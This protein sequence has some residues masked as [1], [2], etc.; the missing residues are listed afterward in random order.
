MFTYSR[1][2]IL[3]TLAGLAG[4]D[5]EDV[6][7]TVEIVRPVKTAVIKDRAQL[8]DRFFVGVAQAA[9]QATLGFSVAGT[10]QSI[11]VGLGQTVS[12]GDMIAQLDP[13]P[14]QT[15]V[16]RLEAELESAVATFENAELQT[17][18]QRELVARD[19]A[20]E[21]QLDRFIA[22]ESSAR[23]AVA[24]VTASLE[25]ARLN[26]SYT[27]I[28]APFDGVVV[29]TYVEEFEDVLSQA[30]IVRILDDSQIEMVIDVPERWISTL[31][32]VDGF[33]ATF[34][35]LDGL[36]L[37]AVVNEVGTEASATTGTFPVTLL[38]EQPEDRKILPGM[39]GRAR[40]EPREGEA[41]ASG[42]FVPAEGIFT[43]EGETG[44]FVW[45]IDEGAM[46]VAAREVTL[47]AAGSLGISIEGGLAAGEKVVAAGA[48]TLRDGQTVRF[49][50]EEAE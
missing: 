26:L 14:F 11:E 27:E 20:A 33:K 46:A 38:I 3:L 43:P 9:R 47:G 45:V 13:A 41:P 36:F 34:S 12:E 44:T 23:A 19:V 30:S 1:L 39:T 21:A 35:A 5:E 29:A 28:R 37:P 25:R 18:R 31:P 2:I 50:D 15:E 10:V 49:M 32:R 42:I 17:N 4:C 22:T 16:A 8:H 24:G 48:N 7:D 40:G 6:S